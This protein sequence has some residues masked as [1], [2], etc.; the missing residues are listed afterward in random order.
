MRIIN[1]YIVW[2]KKNLKHVKLHQCLR[3]NEEK[4]FIEEHGG[5][6]E[7]ISLDEARELKKM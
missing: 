1:T 6:L 3:F 7:L 2:D 4:F 5:K